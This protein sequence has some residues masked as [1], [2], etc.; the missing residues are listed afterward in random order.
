MINHI[1]NTFSFLKLKSAKNGINNVNS[2]ITKEQTKL[3]Y[4]SIKLLPNTT[5]I[6]IAL[7]QEGKTKFIGA[8]RVRDTIIFTENQSSIFQIGSISKVFTAS[9]LS[10][11][12]FDQ[13]I[14]LD[15]NIQDF[16]NFR[17]NIQ[18]V[19]T[20]KQLAN[21][22]SG[23]PKIPA[24]FDFLPFQEDNPYKFYDS[25]RLVTYLSEDINLLQK[26]GNVSFPKNRTV[27][28]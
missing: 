25:K 10:S 19:I 12:V 26:A 22:T 18:D 3:I 27:K 9:L 21:H 8:K 23:L 6:S 11:F 7:I 17:L 13:T 20:F 1:I 2:F 28:K 14:E 15:D 5:E 16:I 24:N 4:N